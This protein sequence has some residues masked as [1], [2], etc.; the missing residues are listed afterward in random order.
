MYKAE[1]PKKSLKLNFPLRAT[2]LTSKF[3]A[4]I[5]GELRET[6]QFGSKVSGQYK[7]FCIFTFACGQRPAI[8]KLSILSRRSNPCASTFYFLPIY[9][10][11]LELQIFQRE[12]SDYKS[13]LP[14]LLNGIS[15]V[16]QGC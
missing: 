2:S 1:N 10:S 15:N 12:G 14:S 3:T 9:P 13:S 11:H 8:H 4:N 7:A 6:L 16:H 5:L